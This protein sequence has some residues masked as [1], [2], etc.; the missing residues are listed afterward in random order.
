M[1]SKARQSYCRH[2]KKPKTSVKRDW[3]DYNKRMKLRAD[4]RLM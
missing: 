2:S 1:P 4:Y 3:F